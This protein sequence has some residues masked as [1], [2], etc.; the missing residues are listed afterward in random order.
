ML[1]DPVQG[2]V[3]EAAG[4]RIVRMST[5]PKGMSLDSHT[6]AT[7]GLIQET[8]AHPSDPPSE[9]TNQ[10]HPPESRNHCSLKFDHSVRRTWSVPTVSYRVLNWNR[11]AH[12]EHPQ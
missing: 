1:L 11:K 12:N 3:D 7:E 2:L 10:R 6:I 4:E 8:T 9:L 5:G